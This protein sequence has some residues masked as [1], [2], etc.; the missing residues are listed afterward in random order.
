MTSIQQQAAELAEE[1]RNWL[2]SDTAPRGVSSVV[3]DASELLR[4]IASIGGDVE[5]MTLQELDCYLDPTDSHEPG[6]VYSQQALAAAR[7]AG[8]EAGRRKGL[9]DAA[10][11]CDEVKQWYS[12]N[13]QKKPL[14]L[15]TDAE[16]CA[17]E[18]GW[19][20][21]ELINKEA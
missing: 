18:C 21:R 6:K 1:M 4:Q 19:Y 2:T 13:G 20:I 8:F 9:E 7:L 15:R 14:N 5:P 10:I 17:Y 3:F 16:T 11:R 12:I